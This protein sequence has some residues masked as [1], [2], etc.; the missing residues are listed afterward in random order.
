[1]GEMLKENAGGEVRR[2]SASRRNAEG[3]VL[4]IECKQV[5][6]QV[7]DPNTPRA[8]AARSGSSCLRQ[9]SAPGPG[10]SGCMRKFACGWGANE[11]LQVI[12]ELGY[13]KI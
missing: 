12:R 2:W 13:P 7:A 8:Q 5:R 4:R 10:K 6:E 11:N 1:M 9:G 3:E